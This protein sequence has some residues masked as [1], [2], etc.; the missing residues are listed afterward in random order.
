[1]TKKKKKY[2]LY[3]IVWQYPFVIQSILPKRHRF[4][5]FRHLAL[6]SRRVYIRYTNE[7]INGPY[8]MA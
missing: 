6:S 2:G 4:C 7:N 3:Y 8:R 5:R 1:M